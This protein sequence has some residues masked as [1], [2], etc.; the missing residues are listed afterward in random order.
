MANCGP[1]LRCAIWQMLTAWRWIW[2]SCALRKAGREV[3]QV[4]AKNSSTRIPS[5]MSQDACLSVLLQDARWNVVS[6]N[7]FDIS[8]IIFILMY[9]NSCISLFLNDEWSSGDKLDATLN[10]TPRCKRFSS[11][12]DDNGDGLIELDEHGI[13]GHAVSTGWMWQEPHK[14]SCSQRLG[15]R[16]L[17]VCPLD[18]FEHMNRC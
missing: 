2:I 13:Q 11:I 1:E 7:I 9:I 18:N 15:L 10:Q 12:F 6:L 3:P 8:L 16:S 5:E 4:G 14:A 17:G